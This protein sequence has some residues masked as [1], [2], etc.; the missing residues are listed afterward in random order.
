MSGATMPDLAMPKRQ[1]VW[2]MDGTLLDSSV[3]VPAAFLAAVRRLGGPLVTPEQVVASY[4]IGPAE[5]LLPHLLGR[6]LAAGES[7]AYYEELAGVSVRPYCG[8]AEVLG[9]LRA[10]GHRIA[11]F[12]GASYRAASMLLTGA[13][14]DL[15]VLVGGDEVRQPKP[16]GDGLLLV[17][18]R[19]GI[20]ASAIAYIGDAPNDMGA[21][22][23]AG[24]LSA[25]AAWG[26]QYD[27]AV[28]A[29]ITLATPADALALLS[30]A[31]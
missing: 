26:H 7:E 25:A 3:A 2:D 29:D 10:R 20:S 4:P 13:G 15:D 24:S 6:E 14:I 12:T 9:A 23:A 28:P 17:A 30:G 1:L 5:A 22:R 8:I 11:V 19:L 16:A 31:A 27:A 21:A 18:G